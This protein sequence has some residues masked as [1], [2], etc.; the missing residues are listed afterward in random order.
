MTGKALS[1]GIFALIYVYAAE[2][3]PTNLRNVGVGSSSTVARV[4]GL[5]QPQITL[6]VSRAR[7]ALRLVSLCVWL[8]CGVCLPPSVV[9]NLLVLRHILLGCV[10]FMA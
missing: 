9:I 7:R 5:I 8:V 1:A 2:V 6:T 4:G 10:D 3:F